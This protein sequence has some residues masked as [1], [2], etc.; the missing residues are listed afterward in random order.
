[1]YCMVCELRFNKAVKKKIKMS[2]SIN[3]YLFREKNRKI[4][5]PSSP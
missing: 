4:F 5:S 3:N 2:H 1:M